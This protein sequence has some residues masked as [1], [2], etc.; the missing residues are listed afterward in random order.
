MGGLGALPHEAG[1]KRRDE[2]E[3]GAMKTFCLEGKKG[4]IAG[5]WVPLSGLEVGTE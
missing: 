1:D 2:E 4:Q 3:G 5:L